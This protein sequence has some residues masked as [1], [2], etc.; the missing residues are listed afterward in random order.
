M[1]V[2]ALRMETHMFD[3][4]IR[5]HHASKDPWMPVINEEL[6]CAQEIRNPHDPYAVVIKKG[7]KLG[8]WPR[9]E[10]NFSRLFAVLT[11]SLARTVSLA[12][13]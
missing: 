2:L 7:R 3:S 4:C 9:S 5:G 10:K 12:F 1:R 8:C 13:S 6:V 11:A